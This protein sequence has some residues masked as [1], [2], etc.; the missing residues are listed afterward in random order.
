MLIALFGGTGFIGSYLVKRLTEDGLRVRLAIRGEERKLGRAYMD[1]RVDFFS[2]D[3]QNEKSVARVVEGADAV[4]NL[5]G[6]LNQDKRQTFALVHTQLPSAIAKACRSHKVSQLVHISALGAALDAPSAYL[7]SKAEGEEAIAAADSCIIIRPSIVLGRESK[8]VQLMMDMAKRT[9]ML[10]LPFG[11]SR[12][13]PIIVGD[14]AQLIVTVIKQKDSNRGRILNAAGPCPMSIRQL[15]RLI[16]SVGQMKRL[17]VP[18]NPSLSYALAAV[19]E[20]T[21]RKPPVTKD[22]CL[23]LSKDYLCPAEENHALQ[24]LG[25]LSDLKQ[26]LQ[27]DFAADTA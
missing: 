19:M 8:F 17:L 4:I 24:Q 14:L 1:S 22:N 6:T 15:A 9:P 18:L 23:S 20:K 10:L 13:Q 21:L 25:D 2:Y 11:L 5:I 7:R 12:V 3:S 27:Q 26:A 16:L